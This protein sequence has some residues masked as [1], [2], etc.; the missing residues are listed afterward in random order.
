MKATKNY[1]DSSPFT[2][3]KIYRFLRII[4]FTGLC[5]LPKIQDYWRSNSLIFNN[6]LVRGSMPRN[7]FRLLMSTI[8][9][10][11]FK[12]I[13]ANNKL[14]KIGQLYEIANKIYI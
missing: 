7:R 12:N 2:T 3:I 8:H 6:T 11:V 10:S 9:F 4:L 13:K 5:K 14:H 1:S